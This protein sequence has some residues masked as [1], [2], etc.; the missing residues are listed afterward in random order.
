MSQV[1]KMWW[2]V[3]KKAY[4]QIRLQFARNFVVINAS[5]VLLLFP[6]FYTAQLQVSSVVWQL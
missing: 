3:F 1:V 4:I 5:E 6:D 2:S